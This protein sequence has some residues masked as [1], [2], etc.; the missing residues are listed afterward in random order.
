VIANPDTSEIGGHQEPAQIWRAFCHLAL[1]L[2]HMASS[3][4]V[5]L[6]MASS[7]E[8]VAFDHVWLVLPALS[9]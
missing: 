7:T 8:A 5:H 4:E 6:T 9:S 2:A 3:I 1:S